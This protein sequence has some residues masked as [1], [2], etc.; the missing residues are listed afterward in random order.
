MRHTAEVERGDRKERDR[1]EGETREDG[2]Q[3][4]EARALQDVTSQPLALETSVISTLDR[5]FALP[6]VIY[7]IY[8][9][10]ETDTA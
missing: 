7:S 4:F 8:R 6:P 2:C 10:K 9:D 3:R 1:D 5:S